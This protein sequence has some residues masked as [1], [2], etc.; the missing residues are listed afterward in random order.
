MSTHSAIQRL[1]TAHLVHWCGAEILE[2]QEEENAL[3][4]PPSWCRQTAQKGCGR[5]GLVNTKQYSERKGGEESSC[6]GAFCP[7]NYINVPASEGALQSLAGS[8]PFHSLI[9]LMYWTK[10]R[11]TKQAVGSVIPLTYFFKAS[12]NSP[13]DCMHTHRHTHACSNIFKPSTGAEKG[14]LDRK[15]I[16]WHTTSFL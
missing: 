2:G 12:C 3:Y 13:N 16:S 11:I 10:F 8:K 15:V 9:S 14:H 4:K 7:W 1:V 5:T 6:T